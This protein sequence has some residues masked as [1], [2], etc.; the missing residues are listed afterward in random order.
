V[1]NGKPNPML[2]IEEDLLKQKG[3]TL[4]KKKNKKINK[5]P[6]KFFLKI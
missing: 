2:Y 6:Q 1:G 3:Q 5:K 4:S